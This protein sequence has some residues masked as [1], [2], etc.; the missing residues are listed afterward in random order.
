MM[1]M[2]HCDLVNIHEAFHVKRVCFVFLCNATELA[3]SNGT[4]VYL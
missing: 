3:A 4:A 1:I 2:V